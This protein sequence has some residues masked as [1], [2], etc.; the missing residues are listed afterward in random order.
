MN[1]GD[2][3]GAFFLRKKKVSADKDKTKK[4]KISSRESDRS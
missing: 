4:A 2:P 1:V 3:I